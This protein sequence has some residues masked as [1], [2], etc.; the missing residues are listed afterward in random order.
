VP[1]KI[2]TFKRDFH[3]L[4]NSFDHLNNLSGPADNVCTLLNLPESR[5]SFVTVSVNKC[6]T[7]KA[8]V[9]HCDCFGGDFST[10]LGGSFLRLYT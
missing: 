5:V 4:S 9:W 10:Q 8:D 7:G 2:V 3:K 6:E 1:I